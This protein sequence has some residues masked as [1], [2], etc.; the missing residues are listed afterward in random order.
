MAR[1]QRTKSLDAFSTLHLVDALSSEVEAW[2]NQGWTGVTQTTYELLSY[3]F[4]RD[5]EVNELFYDCQQRAIETVIYC[6][7]VLQAKTL[8]ELYQKL[9]PEALLEHAPLL[10]EIEAIPFPKYCLKMATGSGKTWVLAALL[11]WQYFNALRN[12]PRGKYSYRFLIVAPGHE[13]LNRLLDSVKGKRDPKTGL[14]NPETSDYK[15]NLF[16]PDNARWRGQFNLIFLDPSEVRANTPPP[17][18]PFVFLTNWQQFRLKSDKQSLWE[19]WT[20]E[21]VE[22]QPRGEVIADFLSEFPDLVV[23][24]DEAHHVHGAKSAS[25]EELVW[26]R[27]MNVLYERLRENHQDRQGVFLQT[28]FS[29]TPFYGSGVK[30]EYFPHIVYD[31]DLVQAMRDMLVKQ[32]FLE[33]RQAIGGEQLKDLD[34]R[35]ERT[36]AEGRQRGQVKAL[37]NGQKLLLDIGRK[38]LEQLAEEFRQQGIERKPVMMVLAEETEVAELV[39]QH[40]STLTDERGRSYDEKQVMVIHSDLKDKE[41]ETARLRLDKIDDENDPLRVVVSVLMLREGFDK[42]NICVVVVLRATEAD[43]LLEQLVGRGLR[44]MFPE[45]RYPEF[46]DAKVEAVEDLRR[47]R[48]PSNSL[49]FLFIVEHPRFRTFYDELRNQGYL[50]GGGDSSKTR[51][52]GDIVPVDAMPARIPDYDIAWAE[53]IFEQG[54]LPDLSQLDVSS[55]ARY[56]N[57]FGQLRRTLS[58]L[59][60]TD[61]HVGTGTKARTWKLDN[62]YFDYAHFLRRATQAIATMG[63]NAILTGKQTEIAALVDEYVS[64][65]LFGE[66]IDF[67]SQKNYQV[68]NFTLVFDHI[69]NQM[70]SNILREAAKAQYEVRGAWKKLSELKRIMV[71][72]SHTVETDKCIYP[73]QGYA[74]VGGGFE[75]NFMRET[76]NPS[77]DVL[78]FAKL[79]R[80]HGLTIPYRD[81]DGIAR[82][83]EVDFLVRA[84]DAI[85]L[86]ET[87]GDRDLTS[88]T[89]ALKA[90]A[91]QA[92]CANAASVPSSDELSQPTRWEYLILSEGTY[93]T[94]RGNSFEALVPLCR[95]ERDLLVAQQQGLLF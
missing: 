52:G 94:H 27:F 1:T 51:S 82:S 28:D 2:A 86:V 73:L 54:R 44:L 26:R 66:A 32:L 88:P 14:R 60:I 45:Y 6:H 12:E 90:R 30:K 42:N 49:D 67:N 17:D 89:V 91:A 78:A 61:R 48:R 11:V 43:L 29:A 36:E 76:L 74:S 18:G 84:E 65:Y 50:I 46:R 83:Y 31:Y 95:A 7:E 3:C 22:D 63:K 71:R 92:W 70:R 38:K 62:Q 75:R 25:N 16:M 79:D 4:N 69:V 93:Q 8:G 13:V 64:D 33:E 56:P 68:L 9:A 53:Q 77:A 20:G 34:F 37:S 81:E 23:M 35:A 5:E 19:Q 59:Q 58:Q 85:Y 15:R 55:L 47:R 57:D 24:N 80:K 40:V 41:L 87:K 39:V 72:E 21:D 10:A